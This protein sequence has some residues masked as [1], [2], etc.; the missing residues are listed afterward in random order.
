MS[1]N[2][3]QLHNTTPAELAELILQG[4]EKRLAALEKNFQPKEPDEFLTRKETAE[5]LRISFACL[6]DWSNKGILKPL[7][8]GNRTYYSR[9][10]IEETLYNSN[11]GE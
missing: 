9:K 3:T 8:H 4:V 10:A 11:A 1:N 2:V 7:K 6:H 5:L